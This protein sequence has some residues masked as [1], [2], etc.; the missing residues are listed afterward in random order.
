MRRA[1]IPLIAAA[2]CVAASCRRKPAEPSPDYEKASGLYQQLY[3]TELDDAYADPKMDVVVAHLKH[4]DPSS[5]DADAAADLLGTID[6]G[7]AG[8]SK[9]RAEEAKLEASTALALK[10][11]TINPTTVLN[12]NEPQDA[13]AAADPTGEGASIADLNQQSGG[14]LVADQPFREEGTG[15]TGTVYKL[16]V[17]SACHDKLP[18]FVGQAVMVIDGK[19]YRRVPVA[20]TRQET[21][22][23]GASGAGTAAGAAQG[24]AAGTGGAVDAGTAAAAPRPAQGAPIPANARLV[25]IDPDGTQHY[26]TTSPAQMPGAP[27][28]GA[29]PPQSPD[30][31][32]NS[33]PPPPPGE[34]P[35][36]TQPAQQQ[37]QY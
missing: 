20:D 12:A 33:T 34:N 18:G 25:R 15:K 19:I 5:A 1:C 29:Q 9:Q 3:A 13:G 26:E 22:D 36:G 7:R 37:Q 17:Y 27:Q 32:P 6:R 2:L 21:T 8:L 16:S 35:D 28:P 23:A 30:A 14:C 11:P 24:G 4:V 10:Q 31:L